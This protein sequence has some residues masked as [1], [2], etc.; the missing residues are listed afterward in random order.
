MR[1]ITLAMSMSVLLLMTACGISNDQVAADVKQS[2]QETMNTNPDMQKM[3]LRI[4]TVQVMKQTG[5]QYVGIAK[6]IH[7][8]ESHDVP[9][10]I[11]ADGQGVMW[12]TQPG[13]F[14]FVA[15]KEM[16]NLFKP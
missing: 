9:V 15:Q 12:S 16:R 7:A 4:E 6:V 14:L 11:T 8:G 5:N 1:R 13:A 10:Q 2:M 3:N